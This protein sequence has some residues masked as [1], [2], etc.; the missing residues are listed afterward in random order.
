M[1]GA[2]GPNPVPPTTVSP[3]PLRFAP[4][5]PGVIVS[6]AISGFVNGEAV[7][8]KYSENAAALCG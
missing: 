6:A 5:M 7:C 3:T 1:V 4:F 2:T 8:C